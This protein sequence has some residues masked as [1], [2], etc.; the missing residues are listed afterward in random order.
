NLD[1]DAL[2]GALQS[3]TSRYEI[4]RTSF[5]SLPETTLPLQTITEEGKLLI[6]EHSL[7]GSDARQQEAR[8]DSLLRE[9]WR[10][11]LDFEGGVALRA[12]LVCISQDRHILILSL[13]ALCADLASLDCL[14]SEIGRAYSDRIY[15]QGVSGDVIQYADL[16]EILNELL[17]SESANIGKE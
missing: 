6:G 12:E 14:V 3:I 9:S 17:D 2:K 10:K 15:G 16:A 7:V 8:I 11:C 5:H 4:L 13:P 1:G